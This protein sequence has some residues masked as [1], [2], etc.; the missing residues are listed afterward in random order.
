MSWI[1]TAIGGSALI[2]A[3]ASIY[4]ADKQSQAAGQAAQ[5]QAQ[6]AQNA[7]NMQQ[8]FFNTA[9]SNLQPF[10]QSG[11]SALPTLTKLLTPGAD[12]SKVLSQIPG[13]QF[14]QQYGQKAITNQATSRGLSGN[15]LSAGADY[16]TGSAN[17]AYGG[18]VQAL[19]QQAGIGGSA[20]GALAGS[21]GTFGGQVGQSATNIGTALAGGT[22]GS[23]NALSGGAT[24][25]ANALS[26]G[27][28]GYMN[29]QLLQGLINKNSGTQNS[30]AW[31]AANPGA[32]GSAYYGPV[33][34]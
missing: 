15:A 30:G 28:N 6:A 21:A 31:G 4:S 1:A 5:L 33:A 26:G 10:I 13:F 34:P 20:A 11:S 24:G 2:G 27:A 18:I 29:Y 22:L 17:S 9:N 14:A 23:A 16:A 12:M 3:G 25:V 7:M 8:G 32:N 19:L